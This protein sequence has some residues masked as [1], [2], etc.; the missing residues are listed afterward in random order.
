MFLNATAA[1]TGTVSTSG[2]AKY[3]TSRFTIQL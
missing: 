3:G 2:M 1:I